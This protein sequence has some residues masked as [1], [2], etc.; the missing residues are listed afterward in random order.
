MHQ[1]VLA[2]VSANGMGDVILRLIGGSDLCAAV[3]IR[4]SIVSDD[5]L[6][7]SSHDVDEAPVISPFSFDEGGVVPSM[8][9]RELILI[10]EDGGVV[11]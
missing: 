10:P 1:N 5:D 8:P 11:S 9:G 7:F 4:R 3:S 6:I 2:V